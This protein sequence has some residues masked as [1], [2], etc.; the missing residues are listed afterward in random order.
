MDYPGR[1]SPVCAKRLAL[2][3]IL[4]GRK[5]QPISVSTANPPYEVLALHDGAREGRR[6]RNSAVAGV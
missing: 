2:E 4:S 6:E 3:T 5:D 1:L